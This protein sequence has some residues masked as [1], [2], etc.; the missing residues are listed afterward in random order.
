MN[1]I[2]QLPN[3][4]AN[5]I[6]RLLNET[7]F[8]ILK[9]AFDK[10]IENESLK[11]DIFLELNSHSDFIQDI[12]KELW[13]KE[14]EE[15]CCFVEITLFYN[16]LQDSFG[17]VGTDFVKYDWKEKYL[18]TTSYLEDVESITNTEIEL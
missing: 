9:I 11:N 18:K 17:I 10:K 13:N 14:Q 7:D 6:L 8:D 3:V 12:C 1:K 2:K 15:R 5:I 16:E 4:K